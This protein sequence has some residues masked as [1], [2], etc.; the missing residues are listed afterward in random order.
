MRKKENYHSTDVPGLENHERPSM[1]ISKKGVNPCQLHT[2]HPTMTTPENA[3]VDPPFSESLFAEIRSVC[4]HF[5][6]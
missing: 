5:E 3:K 4:V 6:A 1:R 2:S